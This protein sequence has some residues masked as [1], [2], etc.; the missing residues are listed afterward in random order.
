[1]PTSSFKHSNQ[2]LLGPDLL[3]S[4]A[5]RSVN[6]SAQEIN[7]TPFGYS[8]SCGIGF[9]GQ[10][11]EP[12]TGYYLLGN[13]YRAYSPSLMRFITACGGCNDRPSRYR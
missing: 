12:L 7:Y 11:K 4:P 3:D 8:K 2:A 10:K 13:G 6:G 9:T 5:L 1:M